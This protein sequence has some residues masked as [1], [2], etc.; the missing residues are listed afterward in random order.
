MQ[1]GL[2]GG[3]GIPTTLEIEPCYNWLRI[4]MGLNPGAS[5]KEIEEE[6][7]RLNSSQI[8]VVDMTM[9]EEEDEDDMRMGT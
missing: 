1:R 2:G 7:E 6:K 9:E 5:E 8:G 4:T 3:P